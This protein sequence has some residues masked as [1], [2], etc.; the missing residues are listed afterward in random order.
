MIIANYKNP[1][2]MFSGGKDSIL[3]LLKLKEHLHH[4]IVVWVNTGKNFPE[5]LEVIERFKPMTHR[6]VELRSD[7]DRQWEVY[8]LP[9]DIINPELTLEGSLY[10]PKSDEKMQSVFNCCSMNIMQPAIKF[11]KSIGCELLIRGQRL[12]DYY[13]DSSKTGDVIEGITI[14]NPLENVKDHE[15]R[16]ILKACIDLPDHILTFQHTSLD[17]MDCTGYLQFSKDRIKLLK[18]KY[19]DTA[20][21]LRLDLA[22]LDELN[23]RPLKVLREVRK[24]LQ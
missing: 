6:W 11:I 14:Y 15:V 16:A 20:N 19:P 18:E 12:D 9:S 13:K 24:C 5:T 2:L 1:V 10:S 17:C 3:C 22:F 21:R 8:G 7:R 4:I 23:S